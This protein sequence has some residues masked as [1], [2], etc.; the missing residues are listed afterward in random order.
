MKAKIPWQGSA[1]ERRAMKEEINRQIVE[2]NREYKN[3]FDAMILWTLHELCGFGKKRL[4]EVYDAFADKYDELV[5]HYEAP[6]KGAWIANY[7]LREIGVDISAWNK[8]R[9]VARKK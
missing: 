7:K 4:R 6:D 8:E 1:E 2:T 5:D 3:D 9:E